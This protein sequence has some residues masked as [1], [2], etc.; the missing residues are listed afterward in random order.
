MLSILTSS[1]LSAQ[2]L[3][4]AAKSNGFEDSLNMVVTDFKNN[5]TSIQGSNLLAGIDAEAYQSNICLPGATHCII[6]RYHSLVD[7]SASWQATFYSGENYEEALKVYK[8]IFGQLKKTKLKGINGTTSSFEGNMETP[9]ENV[10]FA[11]SSFVLKSPDM[12]YANFAAAVELINN[13]DGWE[14]YLNMYK[15]KKDTDGGHIR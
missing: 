11:V 13:Y 6:M 8:K 5:F 2:M 10:R 14:V 12:G 3:K 15:K 9:D 4:P 7:K 1:T